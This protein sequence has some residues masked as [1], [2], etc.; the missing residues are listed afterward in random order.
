MPTTKHGGAMQKL[1]PF[2]LTDVGRK[3]DHNE[4][5]YVVAEEYE[6]YVVCDGMGGHASG[7]V[8]SRLTAEHMVGFFQEHAATPQ[9]RL[10]YKARGANSR[11]EA[12]LS[13]AVQYA[14]DRVYVEGMKDSK[15]E[16]MG[17]T[18]VAMLAQRDTF[19]L[20]HVGDSRIY[21]WRA[22][23]ELEQITR[24]HSLL[25]HKI[26]SGELTTAEEISNF[27]QG[28]IIVRAVGLKDY[29]EPEVQ[30][31]PRR[32]EDVFLLCSDG[33]SDMVD[34]WSMQNVLEVNSDD[35]QEAAGC[36]VRMANDRGGKDNI[37]VMLVRVD[38]EPAPQNDEVT[39]PGGSV[40]PFYVEDT[41]P[42]G[43]KAAEA[44]LP[45]QRAV[46][47]SAHR[48]FDDDDE[49]GF[50]GFAETTDPGLRD[51]GDAG[52]ADEFDHGP[53]HE[54]DHEDRTD[55]DK[56]AFIGFDED[57]MPV[58]RMAVEVRSGT[59]RVGAS[60]G[61]RKA[62][63]DPEAATRPVGRRKPSVI[64]EEPSII[65]DDSLRKR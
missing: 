25:N 64:V 33:L 60:T 57:D 35:L 17:T 59:T 40:T 27:K 21:R 56:P 55:V 15:L 22:G 62:V 63:A 18:L 53:G 11:A 10:P 39:D 47:A 41:K 28:N 42:S 37:T 36:L 12:M 8:A 9:E 44:T 20:A 65:V 3:R 32:P 2:A 52:N 50:D 34:D 61:D 24:D 48:D 7:E 45:V 31:V 51:D 46:P 38:D 14:N 43:I 1:T 49:P 5:A 30:T 6:L 26:D 29:V 58:P 16:G 54:I 4:D 23:G 19:V 13:N